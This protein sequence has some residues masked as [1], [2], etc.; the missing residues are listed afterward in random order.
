MP[1]LPLK[2]VVGKVDI[3][4][5]D[6]REIK[7]LSESM[8]ANGQIDIHMAE[9]LAAKYL[10]GADLC[11][12]LDALAA[13]L[14]GNAKDQKQKAYNYA[15]LVK[16]SEVKGLKTDKMRTAFAELDEDYVKACEEYNRALAF[17][18][19]VKSKHDSFVRFHYLSKKILEN[20]HQQTSARS[21]INNDLEEFEVDDE[22]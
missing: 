2:T 20:G 19:W 5:I 7:Q 9:E 14:L 4:S 15:F 1:N 17:Q 12:E 22:W 13:Q 8:P 3:L 11:G 18:K 16:S 10:R 6:T 21:M